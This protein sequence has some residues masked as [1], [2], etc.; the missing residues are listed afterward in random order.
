MSIGS[1]PISATGSAVDA[2]E[3]FGTG[4]RP[5]PASVRRHSSRRA[6]SR[7]DSLLGRFGCLLEA[8]SYRLR[9]LED[10]VRC[11]SSVGS[12]SNPACRAACWPA[13]FH[14]GTVVRNRRSSATE[15]RTRTAARPSSPLQPRPASCGRMPIATSTTQ[16]SCGAPGTRAAPPRQQKP[17][18]VSLG[19]R[20]P[21]SSPR[22]VP[23]PP[24]R[25]RCARHQGCSSRP[26]PGRPRWSVAAPGTEARGRPPWVRSRPDAGP[27]T[28]RSPRRPGR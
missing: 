24:A 22:P 14:S 11:W 12:T 1:V 28:G 15:R 10:L 5:G 9:L 7:R 17:S 13:S 8:C 23:A 19:R 6:W 20:R 26:A 4:R 16:S 27:V 2:F 18:R 21:P 3:Q 25:L